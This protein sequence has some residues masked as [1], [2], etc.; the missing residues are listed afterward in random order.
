MYNEA[1]IALLAQK[2]PLSLGSPAAES[3]KE[4]WDQVHPLFSR[5]KNHGKA[6]K[7]VSFRLFVNRLESFGLEET[8]CE[9]LNFFYFFIFFF[10]VSRSPPSLAGVVDVPRL[11]SY[12]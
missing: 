4:I 1:C 7:V 3:W 11:S 9:L 12:K 10:H 6:T 8:Y 2:H 5:A